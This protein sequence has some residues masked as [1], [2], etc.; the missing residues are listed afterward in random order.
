VRAWK[1]RRLIREDFDKAF[2]GCDVVMGP[3][4]PTAAFKAGEKADD[5]LAM[6]LS[7]VYTISGNLAGI[8]GVSIPCGFTAS[9]L[10]IGLQIQAAPFEEEKLLRIARMYERAADW[11]TRRPKL[12]TA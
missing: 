7:D 2:A 1:V 9:G 12:A 10:P 5:P 11:Y 3:T 6:Y 8:P 4:T